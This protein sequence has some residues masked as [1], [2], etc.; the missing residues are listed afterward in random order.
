MKRE[1]ITIVGDFN[2]CAATEEYHKIMKTLSSMGFIQIV[3]LP[4]H[5]DGRVIDHVYVLSPNDAKYEVRHLSTYFTDHDLLFVTKVNY[6]ESNFFGLL[7]FVFRF[8]L[9]KDNTVK[10]E[11]ANQMVGRVMGWEPA[12]VIHRGSP[13]KSH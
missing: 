5:K 10:Q 8:E 13:K 1:E 6:Y 4:S 7:I 12:S 9:R 11:K 3:D 2:I